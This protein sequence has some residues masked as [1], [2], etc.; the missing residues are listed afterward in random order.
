MKKIIVKSCPFCGKEPIQLKTHSFNGDTYAFGCPYCNCFAGISVV[1][2]ITGA[3]YATEE[4]AADA[5]NKRSGVDLEYE[6]SH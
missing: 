6:W 3:I 1:G 4:A 5:W 2:N